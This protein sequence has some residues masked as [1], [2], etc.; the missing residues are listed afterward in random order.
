MA[1][2]ARRAFNAAARQMQNGLTE[3]LR[4]VRYINDKKV[5]GEVNP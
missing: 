4:R 5:R 1:I 2:A 3:G